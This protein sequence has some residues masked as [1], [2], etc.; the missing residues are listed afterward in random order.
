MRHF[1]TM[2]A[3]IGFFVLAFVGWFNEVDVFICGMRALGGAVA[4]YLVVGLAGTII[5]RII[6]DAAVQAQVDHARSRRG[7]S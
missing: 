6:A 1:A 4:L 2:T 7:K 3:V 5:V